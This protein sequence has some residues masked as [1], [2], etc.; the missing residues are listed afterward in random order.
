MP[1]LSEAAFAAAQGIALVV[2]DVDGVLTDGQIL[3]SSAGEEIKAFHVQDGSACKLLQAN[4]IEVAIITGRK[5]AMVSRRA[6]ELGITHLYQGSER[7]AHHDKGGVTRQ[8]KEPDYDHL[9]QVLKLK[10]AQVACIGDDVADIPL[11]KRC[12]L[13]V[14]VPNGHPA[15]QQCAAHITQ[16]AGGQGVAAELA[17]LLL[18]AQ[19]KWPY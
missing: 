5:S 18:R 8:G 19:G 6:A 11:L 15:A 16:R 10:D 7:G 4:G 12:G 13:G 3:Y 9:L 1:P 17:E 14:S 2:F